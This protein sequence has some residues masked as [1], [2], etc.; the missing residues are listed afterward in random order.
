LPGPIPEELRYGMAFGKEMEILSYGKGKA[1]G[2]KE[3]EKLLN[4]NHI[5]WSIQGS[6]FTEPFELNVIFI[7]KDENKI[8]VGSYSM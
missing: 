1:Y 7:D 2:S 5:F 6:L 8:Y 4:S 3:L